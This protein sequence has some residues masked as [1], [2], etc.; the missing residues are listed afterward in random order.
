MNTRAVLLLTALAAATAAA[1]PFAITAQ[2][3]GA[4]LSVAPGGTLNVAAQAIGSAT[5]VR[6]NVS[7]RGTTS[8]TITGVD[9]FGSGDFVATAISVP[10]TLTPGAAISPNFTFTPRTS[11]MALAM[12]ET[13][14]SFA[15]T[16]D[17]NNAAIPDWRPYD[18]TERPT[19]LF[20]VPPR[21]ATDPWSAEREFMSRYETQQMGRTLHR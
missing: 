16:G 9:F 5:Q 8:A 21:L 1:Q 3:G 15:R 6:L 4:T 20:E 2:T 14:L 12:S 11:A 10:Q 13:W 17:P 7:Y 18:L 19:L